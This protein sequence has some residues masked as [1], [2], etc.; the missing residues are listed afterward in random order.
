[1][2]ARVMHAPPTLVNALADADIA[3]SE[4]GLAEHLDSIDPL[5]HFRSEFHIPIVA[6]TETE[7]PLIYL[8]GNSLGLQPKATE[9][10]VKDE[11][12]VWRAQYAK[13]K[14]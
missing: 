13:F 5:K 10:A 2:G 3:L 1:M 9:Q 11:L 14:F 6:N 12:E 7:T 8:C 4:R